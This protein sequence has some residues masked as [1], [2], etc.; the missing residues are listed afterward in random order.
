MHSIYIGSMKPFS[1]GEPQSLGIGI[2]LME[3]IWLT[4]WNV[5]NPVNDRIFTIY[6]LVSR[7]SEPSKVG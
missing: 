5:E 2:L 7:I 3:E 1:E 4:I 6:Q